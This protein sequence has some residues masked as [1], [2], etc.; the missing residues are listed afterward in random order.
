MRKRLRTVSV[1]CDDAI[2][3]NTPS[4]SPSFTSGST[5]AYSSSSSSTSLSSLCIT[6]R[7][8]SGINNNHTANLP[9][10]TSASIGIVTPIPQ[11]DRPIVSFVTHNNYLPTP[12][13]EVK[14]LVPLGAPPMLKMNMNF[15]EDYELNN[16]NNTN[17]FIKLKNATTRTATSTL[18]ARTAFTKVVPLSSRRSSNNSIRSR[19]ITT[20]SPI[21]NHNHNHVGSNS[22][23]NSN[24]NSNYSSSTKK[25]KYSIVSSSCTNNNSNDDNDESSSVNN[26][27]R[28]SL[29][30]SSSSS[31]LIAKKR[32]K[33]TSST[34]VQKLPP[35]KKQQQQKPKPKQGKTGKKFSW[36][37]YPE[38]ECFL[39][40]NR[41]EYLS[42]SSTKNYTTEQRD[43]NNR[44]TARL[45]EHTNSN[46]S[47]DLY[48][49]LFTHCSF[50]QVRDRIRS[51]YK[52]YV[53]SFKR[54]RQRQLRVSGG[55]G[56]RER[57]Q[58]EREQQ[59]AQG[60]K[61]K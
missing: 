52:S 31:S 9:T 7:N 19:S 26:N 37:A 36:K 24:S 13:Y 22:N 42:Y 47:T 15:G 17:K 20:T 49:D 8:K 57:E 45:L 44:L 2:I 12:T 61:Q 14:S 55:G 51:Y 21:S 60:H 59:H 6:P 34:V 35:N 10:A 18:T 58:H 28:S 32:K 50:S 56:E 3:I 40:Q 4:P 5:S 11:R 33:K 54:R 27:T 16:N 38:L 39:I 30:S 48:A 25:R 53:Q 29:S 46:Q 1:A 41:E 23:N 43:Y